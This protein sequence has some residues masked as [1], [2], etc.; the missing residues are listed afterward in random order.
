MLTTTGRVPTQ[1]IADSLLRGD[2]RAAAAIDAELA[3]LA[4]RRQQ[5]H[6]AR[7]EAILAVESQ[8]VHLHSRLTPML[9]RLGQ[10]ESAAKNGA[11]DPNTDPDVRSLL[12]A[13]WSSRRAVRELGDKMFHA[14]ERERAEDGY[15]ERVRAEQERLGNEERE[16]YRRYH[17]AYS[18]KAAELDAAFQR[19]TLAAK[20]RVEAEVASLRQQID[21][22]EQ[23]LV[24]LN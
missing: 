19:T 12:E 9:G 4:D 14:T 13:W 5:L 23:Q 7:A 3:A 11:G 21:G 10:L 1:H 6:A 8:L 24:Q 15:Y 17:A 18:T 16:A 20:A 2:D 22:L